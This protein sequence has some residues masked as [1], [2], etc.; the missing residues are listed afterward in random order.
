MYEAPKL[1]RVGDAREVILGAVDTG[2]DL[3][4]TSYVQDWEY[5]NG[6]PGLSAEESTAG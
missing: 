5:G 4:G 1:N 2:L 3:D 6:G